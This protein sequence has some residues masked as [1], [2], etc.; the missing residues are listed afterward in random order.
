MH[1]VANEKTFFSP[2]HDCW[3][4]LFQSYCYL[5]VKILAKKTKNLATNLFINFIDIWRVVCFWIYMW[6]ICAWTFI[7]PTSMT[8]VH[9]QTLYQVNCK[10]Y[11]LPGLFTKYFIT[12]KYF[13]FFTPSPVLKNFPRMLSA[14][15]YHLKSEMWQF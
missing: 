12:L 15:A 9:G 3:Y 14:K 13:F 10:W 11:L 7:I 2:F 1:I 8:D 6:S 5:H 4:L